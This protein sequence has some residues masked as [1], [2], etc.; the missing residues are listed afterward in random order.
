VLVISRDI[1]IN[2]HRHLTQSNIDEII[3]ISEVMLGKNYLIAEDL[4]HPSYR[5]ILATLD[6]TV[7][8]FASFINNHSDSTITDVAVS[9]DYQGNGLATRLIAQC[10]F[11][12]STL[13][14]ETIECYAW[15]TNGY[16]HLEKPLLR[17]GF[18]PMGIDPRVPD[19]YRED[20]ECPVCGVGC[21][22]DTTLFQK[23][24]DTF[25]I[26]DFNK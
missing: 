20:F 17:N 3:A 23:Q 19:D 1:D 22:C 9:A 18:K 7:V 12:I 6:G 24:T 8:G 26:P 11:E 4:I 13:W 15:M 5:W 2:L 25:D 21:K 16:P 14:V 10:V